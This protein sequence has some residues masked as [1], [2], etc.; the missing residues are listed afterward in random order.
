[1]GLI[2]VRDKDIKILPVFL[3]TLMLISLL[4][5]L[6]VLSE[7]EQYISPEVIK[8]FKVESNLN[9][10]SLVTFTVYVPLRNVN[11]IYY[12]ANEVSDPSS[13][14]YH[15]YLNKDQVEKLFLSCREI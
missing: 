4:L 9:E 2:R 7:Q 11:L 6:A 5:P 15:H 8:G 3:L 1:M 13:P 10:N 14:L 12:Y